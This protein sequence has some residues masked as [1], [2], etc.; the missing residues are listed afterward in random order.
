M[1]IYCNAIV[2]NPIQQANLIQCIELI[3]GTPEIAGDKISVD[4]KGCE[5]E[6]EIMMSLFENYVRH[7]ITII[8]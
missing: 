8:N 2:E 4:F 6:C 7:N 3:G 5:D 1:I